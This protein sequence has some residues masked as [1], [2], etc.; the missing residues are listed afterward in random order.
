MMV[1]PLCSAFT[2]HTLYCQVFHLDCRRQCLFIFWLRLL[3]VKTA[4]GGGGERGGG[5]LP[6]SGLAHDCQWWNLL[7]VPLFVCVCVCDERVVAV[8]CGSALPFTIIA[9][10]WRCLLRFAVTWAF[11]CYGGGRE[12]GA[13][14]GGEGRRVRGEGRVCVGLYTVWIELSV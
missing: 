7:S 2:H 9:S 4:G 8:L 10:K 1:V 6:F 3:E 12:G 11:S 14:E 5:E 13:G